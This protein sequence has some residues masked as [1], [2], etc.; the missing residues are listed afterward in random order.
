VTSEIRTTIE[1]GDVL[2]IELECKNCQSRSIR[3]IERHLEGV[4]KCSVCGNVWPVALANELNQLKNLVSMLSAVT[5]LQ[6]HRQMPFVIRL[7]IATQKV[8]P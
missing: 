1:P 5:S 8:A 7:E 2:A 6:E 4:E 3:P